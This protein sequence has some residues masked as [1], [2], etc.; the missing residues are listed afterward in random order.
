MKTSKSPSVH[1]FSCDT[2]FSFHDAHFIHHSSVSSPMVTTLSCLLFSYKFSA[3]PSSQ[4]RRIRRSV[5]SIFL[6]LASRYLKRKYQRQGNAKEQ[7]AGVFQSHAFTRSLHHIFAP[8]LFRICLASLIPCGKYIATT[9]TNA[10]SRYCD[11]ISVLN[12]A[13]AMTAAIN[14]ENVPQ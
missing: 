14:S 9:A 3:S 7:P 5:S 2:Q 8:F 11:W 4:R 1:L 10:N 6:S 12:S 13:W